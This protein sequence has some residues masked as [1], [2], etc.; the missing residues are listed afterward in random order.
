MQIVLVE[1]GRQCPHHVAQYIQQCKVTRT[2]TGLGTARTR[3]RQAAIKREEKKVI[4]FFCCTCTTDPGY[5]T[6]S[7]VPF[8]SH[9]PKQT[10]SIQPIASASPPTAPQI[11]TAP[12][13]I[14]PPPSAGRLV[15]F[16]SSASLPLCSPNHNHSFP[17]IVETP[18]TISIMIISFLIT[19][20]PLKPLSKFASSCSSSWPSAYRSSLSSPSCLP[21]FLPTGCRSVRPS[22]NC[23]TEPRTSTQRFLKCCSLP[24][25][26]RRC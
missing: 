7:Q 11:N 4:T 3:P 21:E 6:S 8:A 26:E 15:Y 22:R 9:P 19:S 1:L 2:R 10:F 14:F 5:P 20:L 25:R 24:R 18:A 16:I 13:T 17:S 23:I 12:P